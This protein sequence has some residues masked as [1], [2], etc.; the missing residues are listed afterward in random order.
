MRW[1]LLIL[2][3]FILKAGQVVNRINLDLSEHIGHAP[4]QAKNYKKNDDK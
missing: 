4:K 3:L 1:V 2:F